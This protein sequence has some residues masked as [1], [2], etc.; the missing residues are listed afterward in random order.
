VLGEP[1][2]TQF[3]L[4]FEIFGFPVRVHPLHWALGAFIGYSSAM[5]ENKILG[6]VIGIV[7]VFAS[8]LIH[9]LGHA[10]MMRYYGKPARIILY[11][12][13]GLAI[14][15]RGGYSNPY[16]TG[17]SFRP[18]QD[19]GRFRWS[20]IIISFAG[21]LAQFILAAVVIAFSIAGATAGGITAGDAL[22]N[23]LG[24]DNAINPNLML[25]I[26]LL[27]FINIFWA[28]LNLLPVYPLDGGQIMRE[29][30]VGLDPWQGQVRALWVSIIAAVLT[31]VV[32]AVLC[33]GLFMPIMFG[34]LAFQN[35]QMLQRLQGGG[36]R[37]W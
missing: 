2:P 20:Q 12:M 21:P 6:M 25:L 5:P 28:V 35:W 30:L 33:G 18:V 32:G 4:N 7:V 3:D 34:M 24:M 17:D 27:L 13:G 1:Q 11:M 37:P 23:L 29:F 22:E 14:P 9:E 15:D 36:G 19:K 31:G 10:V 26:R 8:I 16:M